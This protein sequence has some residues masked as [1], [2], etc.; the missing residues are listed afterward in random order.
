MIDVFER[1]VDALT[2]GNP[3]AWAFLIIL[4]AGLFISLT[5]GERDGN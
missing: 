5:G 4:L 2:D 3:F 1:L